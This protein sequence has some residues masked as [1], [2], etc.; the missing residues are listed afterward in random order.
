M[1][2]QEIQ[3][4]AQM[5]IQ[6]ALEYHLAGRLPEA[7]Q[8]YRQLLAMRPE[9]PDALFLLGVLC[10]QVGAP[11]QAIPLLLRAVAQRPLDAVWQNSLGNALKDAGRLHE[12]AERYEQALAC[13]PNCVEAHFNLAGVLQLLGRFPAAVSCYER[14]LAIAPAYAVAHSDLGA[15]LLS[16]HR[17]EPAAASLQRA[18]EL[19]PNLA[20]AH[21]NL[22]IVFKRQ[23]RLDEAIAC[24][25]RT[26][27]IQPDHS[28]A[29]MN[30][31]SALLARR[32]YGEA[33]RW[34]R[35]SLALD[36]D[37][38][39]AHQVLAGALLELG[40]LEEARQQRDL[41][42]RRQAVFMEPA[43][44]PKHTVLVLWA[45]AQ[46]N[47]PIDFLL[48]PQTTTRIH[49]MVE[50]ATGAQASALPP[51]D[52]V[53]NAIGDEDSLA[54]AGPVARYL[55]ACDR[56]VINRPEA[57]A[58]TARHRIGERLGAIPGV[59][60]PTTIR[61]SADA[62]DAAMLAASGLRLPLLLR[63]AGSHGG[64]HLAR[65]ETAEALATFEPWR[66]EAYYVTN[67][68]DYRSA[69]GYCRKYRF[70][71]VDR[72]PHAY[73][74]AIGPHWMVHYETAQM[75]EHPWKRA[76]EARF[77]EDPAGVLG[78]QA[79]AAVSAIGQA[80]D[81]DYAGVDCTLLPD[82]R[83]LVFEAN[84]TMLAHPETEHAALAFKNVH[85]GR[86]L[87]AFHALVERLAARPGS[88][89]VP[90]QARSIAADSVLRCCH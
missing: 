65:I 45:A 44:D 22:G 34:S 42:Y 11:H 24:Y 43:P 70:I 17:L 84:A 73:H 5:N 69:D 82:G 15:A 53:F 54:L 23:K 31:G 4:K 76:E 80:L 67:Y 77:L 63:P 86:I 83:V 74:L 79:M 7:E 47:V 51:V 46:G 33:A 57:V 56:P 59:L 38:V 89:Q 20:D 78:M 36:P 29:M 25:Q 60:V 81:L 6:T 75:L 40:Q 61:V 32:E 12:A 35:A 37:Q 72:Q 88:G 1:P 9:Q 16:L 13:D 58:G 26:L 90:D 8:F 64:D 55:E 41:A 19:D 71:F 2:P 39:E 28:R 68:H 62:P 21:N 49:W 85:V 27:A 52:L 30:L 10:R 66:A 87:D 50:Y 3:T 48:P 14:L 18:L